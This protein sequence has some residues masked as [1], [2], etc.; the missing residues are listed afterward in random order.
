MTIPHAHPGRSRVAALASVLA[1][2]L[3]TL[4]AGST[5]SPASAASVDL[6]VTTFADDAAGGTVACPSVDDGEI[7]TLRAAVQAANDAPA[8]DHT[9]ELAAG[10]YVL[11]V[12]GFDEDGGL[13]GDLD[14]SGDVTLVGQ[15]VDETIIDASELDD[16]IL[17]VAAGG[18]LRVEQLTLTG[19]SLGAP[20]GAVRAAGDGVGAVLEIA[21]AMLR[22]NESF[23][24]GGGAILLD[25]GATGTVEGTTLRGNM[26]A[27]SGAAVSVTGGSDLLVDASLLVDNEG[28]ATGRGGALAVNGAGSTVTMTNSTVSGN[29]A[30]RAGGGIFVQSDAQLDVDGSTITDNN[31][32]GTPDP[33]GDG[34]H[35]AN[36]GTLNVNSTIVAGNGSENCNITGTST[37][38]SDGHNL[39]TAETCGFTEASDLENAIAGLRPLA[40]N[41]GPTLTH[42]LAP[43]SQAVDTGGTALTVDQRGEPRPVDGDGDTNADA[44]IGAFEAQRMVGC[45]FSWTGATSDAW[46]VASN[47]TDGFAG[48]VPGPGEDVCIDDDTNLPV[49][50]DADAGDVTIGS[51]SNT[52]VLGG[53]ALRIEGGSLTLADASALDHL[54]LELAGDDARLVVEERLVVAGDSTFAQGTISG[55]GRTVFDGALSVE[56]PGSKT[57]DGHDVEL[58]GTTTMT[59]DNP[60]RLIDASSVTNHGTVELAADAGFSQVLS[61]ATWNV[62]TNHGTIRKAGAVQTL[63]TATL[64]NAAAGEVAIEAGTL[65]LTNGGHSTGA[66][67]VDADA[68]ITFVGSVNSGAP[69]SSSVRFTHDDGSSLTGAG[70]VEATGTPGFDVDGSYDVNTTRLVGTSSTSLSLGATARAS[71][72]LLVVDAAFVDGPGTLDVVDRFAFRSGS[73]TAGLT[74]DVAGDLELDT[75]GRRSLFGASTILVGG[76]ASQ[77]DGELGMGAGSAVTVDGDYTQ[78]GGSIELDDATLTADNLAL[79]GDAELTGSGDVVALSDN[80]GTVSPGTSPGRIDVDGDHTQQVDGRFVVELA[81]TDATEFDRLV[82][83]GDAV[84]DGSLV[85]T[86]LDGFVPTGG[87]E[88]EILRAGTVT[89]AFDSVELPSLPGGR[90]LSVDQRADAVVLVTSGGSGPPPP[91]PSTGP[92]DVC[93]G[94]PDAFPDDAG[95]VHE[96]DID[97]LAA[98]DLL[99]GYDDGTVRATET[100]TRGQAAGMAMRTIELVSG[101]DLGELCPAG[102]DPLVDSVGTFAAEVACLNRLGTL[103]GYADGTFRPSEGIVRAEVATVLVGI[104]DALGLA[105][106]TGEPDRFGDVPV[107]GAHAGAVVDLAAAGVL[108]GY[109]RVRF[110]PADDLTRGQLASTVVRL[111]G[112]VDEQGVWAP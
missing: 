35:V 105:L 64:H 44:D 93:D 91:P 55:A 23:S 14:V 102:G 92:L 63:N 79:S 29:R 39:D 19:G 17:D 90:S 3:A 15:G 8:D 59:S 88:F 4:V 58:G 65:R 107:D 106:P 11:D 42:A 21:D 34:I 22:D 31:L 27:G 67:T 46:D 83:T 73:L 62:L 110:G 20:G 94:P 53:S 98:L 99:E 70:T 95:S 13:T 69:G 89:G 43:D 86:L 96:P 97:C 77:T 48:G 38:V 60:L 7:C 85:V 72:D 6:V 78:T 68:A 37:L 81:G 56:Q 74:V 24:N 32:T 82:V 112:L 5:A 41:G 54:G 61:N 71:T 40:D 30:G 108:E 66:F 76:E 52:A 104:G 18:R 49:V 2:V 1:L 9:I 25:G 80:A 16:R 51:L 28:S 75:D 12:D 111:L 50:I 101:R 109:D 33:G 103:T 10:R 84:L 26:A 87:D 57:V 100:V 47:W 45:L 36:S